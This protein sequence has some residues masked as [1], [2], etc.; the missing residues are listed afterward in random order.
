MD[1]CRSQF[2]VLVAFMAHPDGC[3]DA[4]I[5]RHMRSAGVVTSPSRLRTARLELERMGA[6]VRTEERRVVDGRRRI[7]FRLA[8]HRRV[9]A[10]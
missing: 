7:V 3:T 9:V 8:P 1:V 5:E 10:R 2:H 6:V 4:D